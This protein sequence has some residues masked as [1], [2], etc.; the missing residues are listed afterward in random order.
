MTCFRL[1]NKCT[2]SLNTPT[3]K[4]FSNLFDANFRFKNVLYS[5]RWNMQREHLRTL[6]TQIKTNTKTIGI[7]TVLGCCVLLKNQTLVSNEMGQAILRPQISTNDAHSIYSIS[8]A[9]FT[10]GAVERLIGPNLAT[11]ICCCIFYFCPIR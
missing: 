7:Y 6:F 11:L 5:E 2:F 1:K 8:L 3:G 10:Y 4:W 9:L